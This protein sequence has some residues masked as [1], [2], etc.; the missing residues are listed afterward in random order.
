MAQAG[1]TLHDKINLEQF[2][3]EMMFVWPPNERW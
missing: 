2:A 1:E 3:S